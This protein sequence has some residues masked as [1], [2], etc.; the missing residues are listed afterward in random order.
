MFPPFF[1]DILF[2]FLRIHFPRARALRYVSNEDYQDRTVSEAFVISRLC[3][4][5]LRV[6]LRGGSTEDLVS[7]GCCKKQQGNREEYGE[8]KQDQN[9]N[10]VC[11]CC[12][13]LCQVRE[14]IYWKHQEGKDCYC[15]EQRYQYCYSIPTK[16]Y[17]SR[18]LISAAIHLI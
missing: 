17:C 7:F 2:N 5:M 10:C 8:E 12:C 15:E 4:R 13:F 16:K 3:S 1:Q 14:H 18:G 6:S 11:V 9:R